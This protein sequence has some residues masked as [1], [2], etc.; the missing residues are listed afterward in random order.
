MSPVIENALY[1][2]PY[3]IVATSY[4][5]NLLLRGFKYLAQVP[6]LANARISLLKPLWGLNGLLA[7][8]GLTLLIILVIK[9]LVGLC[10]KGFWS[11]DPR[12]EPLKGID[13]TSWVYTL[14]RALLALS[15]LPQPILHYY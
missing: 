8:E 5:I 14:G 9:I 15:T 3:V 2:L 11:H 13:N 6:Q 7:K 10:H 4:Q 1:R 12:S